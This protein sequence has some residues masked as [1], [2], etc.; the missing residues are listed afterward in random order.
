MFYNTKLVF[1]LNLFRRFNT[2][3]L[4][5]QN[6]SDLLFKHVTWRKARCKCKFYGFY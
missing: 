4:C 3:S 5:N 6:P 2:N 1:D